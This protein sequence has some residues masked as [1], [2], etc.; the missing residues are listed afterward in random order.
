MVD[1]FLMTGMVLAIAMAAIVLLAVR[2]AYQQCRREES[3]PIEERIADIHHDAT[4]MMEQLQE[5]LQRHGTER[6]REVAWIPEVMDLYRRLESLASTPN[7][8]AD[9]CLV[10]AEEG[11]KYVQEMGIKG[12]FVSTQ[13]RRLAKLISKRNAT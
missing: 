10:L 4:F 6:P 7:S 3:R 13:A 2:D 5:A 9:E 11:S 12:V 1:A 8:S